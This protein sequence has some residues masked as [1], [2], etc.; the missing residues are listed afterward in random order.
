MDVQEHH[1]LNRV[2]SLWMQ[3]LGFC[4]HFCNNVFIKYSPSNI[5]SSQR[6]SSC[7]YFQQIYFVWI[8]LK[9][10]QTMQIPFIKKKK[11]S[12]VTVLLAVAASSIHK[13]LRKTCLSSKQRA[14]FIFI[15]GR[16]Q[17]LSQDATLIR[18]P[19]LFTAV[20]GGGWRAGQ[21][22]HLNEDGQ[23][24]KG[25]IG[26]VNWAADDGFMEQKESAR[27]VWHFLYFLST[28]VYPARTTG[29]RCLR[30]PAAQRTRGGRQR[31]NKLIKL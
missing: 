19:V 30:G 17:L 3:S 21:I 25:H 8:M 4:R 5:I 6:W 28:P 13:W 2:P 1:Q 31:I 15:T 18:N 7:S 22:H 11:K 26:G 16:W 14:T 29:A 12:H 9:T 24:L 10:V 27:G 20:G 23:L